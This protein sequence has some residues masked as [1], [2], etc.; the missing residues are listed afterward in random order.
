MIS[1]P[2]AYCH[3][4]LRGNRY[5]LHGFEQLEKAGKDGSKQQEHHRSNGQKEKGGI[6]HGGPDLLSRLIFPF[7][8]LCHFL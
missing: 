3:Q 8:V 1:K 6:D 4:N 7:E 5:L 2:A